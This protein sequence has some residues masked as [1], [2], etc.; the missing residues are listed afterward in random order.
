MIKVFTLNKNQKIELTEKELKELLD[1]AYWEG[2]NDANKTY[3]YT[4]PYHNWWEGPYYTTTASTSTLN[5]C[6]SNQVTISNEL[7]CSNVANS[8]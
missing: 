7:E 6:V 4:T 1:T 2:R 8:K 5:G 3:I